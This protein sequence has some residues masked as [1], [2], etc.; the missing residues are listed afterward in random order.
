MT[1]VIPIKR[2]YDPLGP[3]QTVK[4]LDALYQ[5]LTDLKAD[6]MLLDQRLGP[7]TRSVD[8]NAAARNAINQTSTLVS[9]AADV[10]L[11]AIAELIVETTAK[12]IVP[13]AQNQDQP[14]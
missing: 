11:E 2:R 5:K 7:D 6:A 12:F 10:I 8:R 3:I 13:P 9:R 4:E 14:S 1:N